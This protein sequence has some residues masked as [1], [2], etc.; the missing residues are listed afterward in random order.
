MSDPSRK[1]SK[2]LLLLPIETKVREYHGKLLLSLIAA[3][4]GFEVLLGGQHALR[5]IVHELRPGIYIDKSIASTKIKWAKWCQRLGHTL[6]AWDEEGLVYF[7]DEIYYDLRLCEEVLALTS[8]FF[9]WGNALDQTIL[10][11]LPDSKDKLVSVGNPRFDLMRSEVREFY[12]PYA[13]KLKERYGSILL[14]NTNFG[15]YNHYHGLDKERSRL[16]KSY[17]LAIKRPDFI[18][19]WINAQKVMFHHFVDMLP[20]L[21]ETFPEHT[22]IIRPHPSENLM[23]WK[24]HSETIQNCYVNNEGNALEWIY[25]SDALIHFNCTTA[26]EAYL[27]GIP[28]IAYRP[29]QLGAFEQKLPNALSLQATTLNELADLLK[30]ICEKRVPNFFLGEDPARTKIATHFLSGLKGPLASDRI[31]DTLLDKFKNIY[32]QRRTIKELG[33]VYYRKLWLTAKSIKEG[34]KQA[35]NYSEKKFPGLTIEEIQG[36]IER[37]KHV[38]GRFKDASVK[39]HKNG[40]FLLSA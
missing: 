23:K 16:M 28:A 19:G 21:R 31:V 34:G 33:A 37:F 30:Q 39:P 36:D 1:H 15:F 5:N 14:L 3:E 4:R 17:P 13:D 26:I 10:K 2:P 11:K 9:T 18:D 32:L 8:L 35:D 12:K 29:D 27:M 7:D 22:I 38:T 20:F 40:C 25:A 24:E 6:V